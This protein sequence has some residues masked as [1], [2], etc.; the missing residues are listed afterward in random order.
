MAVRKRQL[1]P[2]EALRRLDEIHQKTRGISAK[3]VLDALAEDIARE[4]GKRPNF[5]PTGDDA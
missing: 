3:Q 5:D 2:A 1:D 4:T